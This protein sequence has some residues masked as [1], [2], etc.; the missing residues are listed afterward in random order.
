MA[1]QDTASRLIK[2][3]GED[4][5]VKLQIPDAAPADPAKPFNVDPTSK[6]KTKTVNAVVVPIARNLVDGNSVLEGDET[7]L[8]AGLDLGA[9]VPTP[10]FSVIDENTEKNII[11]V[12]RVRP[13][14]TDFLFKL[15]VRAP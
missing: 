6:L 9:I 15:Q 7:M 13:G 14:K 8:I 11:N 5:L 4:R 12:T 3:F 10:E 1:L 2:Q